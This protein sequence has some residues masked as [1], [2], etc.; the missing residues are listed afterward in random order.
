MFIYRPMR[1]LQICN[2]RESM[3]GKRFFLFWVGGERERG[4]GR[5]M[6]GKDRKLWDVMRG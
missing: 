4:G 6:C 3:C 1:Y 2:R 5:W